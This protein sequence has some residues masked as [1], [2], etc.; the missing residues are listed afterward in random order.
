MSR[1][2]GVTG[3]H[4]AGGRK[5]RLEQETAQ[6]ALKYLKASQAP[7]GRDRIPGEEAKSVRGIFVNLGVHLLNRIVCCIT[8]FK[9]TFT[10]FF[11]LKVSC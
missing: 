9:L 4:E 11:I 6:R 1:E 5:R 7:G 8:F 3:G 10:D 2:E